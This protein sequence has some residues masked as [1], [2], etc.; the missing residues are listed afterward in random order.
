MSVT[1]STWVN[2]TVAYELDPPQLFG[3]THHVDRVVVEYSDDDEPNEPPYVDITIKGWRLTSKMTVDRR[4]TERENIYL[5]RQEREE[6]V[7]DD[8][9]IDYLADLSAL[10]GAPV[11][12]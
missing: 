6:Y 7:T 2:V 3:M 12:V 10:L 9:G 4:Q 5:T 1:K 8:L 11:E